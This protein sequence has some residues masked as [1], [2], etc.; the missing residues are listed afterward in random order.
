MSY[1]SSEQNTT[2]MSKHVRFRDPLVESSMH[3]MKHRWDRNAIPVHVQHRVKSRH[4]RLNATRRALWKDLSGG[5]R[6]RDVFRE[7]DALVPIQRESHVK[8]RR[9]KSQQ[10]MTNN[11]FGGRKTKKKRQEDEF[12][13]LRGR[14]REIVERGRVLRSLSADSSRTDAVRIWVNIRNKGDCNR[15]VLLSKSIPVIVRK[16]QSVWSVWNAAKNCNEALRG[17]RVY[18]KIVSKNREGG[19]TTLPKRDVEDALEVSASRRWVF[20]V[21][22]HCKKCSCMRRMH[23]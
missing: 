17:L 3:G 12:F 10:G 8:M 4:H 5:K 9:S 20:V 1:H 21:S 14:K 19:F 13:P 11:A 22:Q 23:F 2:N 7:T 15:N 6:R 16:H 18:P